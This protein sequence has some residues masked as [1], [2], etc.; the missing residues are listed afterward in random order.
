VFFDDRLVWRAGY[1]DTPAPLG[2][3]DARTGAPAALPVQLREVRSHRYL[4]ADGRTLVWVTTGGRTLVTWRP[5]WPA[6]RTVVT[7]DEQEAAQWPGVSGEIVTWGTAEAKFVADLRTG[8]RVQVTRQYGLSRA[9]HDTLMVSQRAPEQTTAEPGQQPAEQVSVVRA[10][11]LPR[12]P[13]C[14]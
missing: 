2:A 3:A 11:T 9:W 7:V 6:P 12:L 13:S 1:D 5:G 10:S 4:A 8:S 14:R